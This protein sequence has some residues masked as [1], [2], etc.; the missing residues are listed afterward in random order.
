MPSRATP[1]TFYD[2]A[3][4]RAHSADFDAWGDLV[5][6]K[7]WSYDGLLNYFRRTE[8]HH[9]P[10]GDPQLMGFEGNIHMVSESRGYPLAEPMRQMYEGIELKFNFNY[11]DGDPLGEFSSA[12]I[13]SGPPR[14]VNT[15]A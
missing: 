1:L 8:H 15:M 14:Y 10:K 5:N 3:W 13:C 6:D 4:T 7:R 9:N 11:N 12:H 2:V